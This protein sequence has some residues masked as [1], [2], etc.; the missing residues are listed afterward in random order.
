M[1]GAGEGPTLMAGG[2][3]GCAGRVLLLIGTFRFQYRYVSVRL[4]PTKQ[5]DNYLVCSL[6]KNRDGLCWENTDAVRILVFQGQTG[7]QTVHSFHSSAFLPIRRLSCIRFVFCES[8]L[9][10][11]IVKL[12]KAFLASLDAVLLFF[13]RRIC[14][15]MP[16]NAVNVFRNR[17]YSASCFDILRNKNAWFHDA[18]STEFR[19]EYTHTARFLARS[20]VCQT[21]CA[22][23][24]PSVHP[25]YVCGVLGSTAWNKICGWLFAV[26]MTFGICRTRFH[27]RPSRSLSTIRRIISESVTPRRLASCWSH[28]IWGDV[29]TIV[30]RMLMCSI[31]AY[32]GIGVK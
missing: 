26:E 28:F 6:Q 24:L 14:R 3:A 5:I 23:L 2:D 32:P 16:W 15:R 31:L 27:S 17:C 19:S 18:A 20:L 8:V 4:L 9:W 7:C 30:V 22:K 11:K 1:L 25:T 21:G 12:S 10:Q 13:C 29:R